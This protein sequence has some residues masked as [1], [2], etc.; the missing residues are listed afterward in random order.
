MVLLILDNYLADMND[1]V[2]DY[3]KTV[4]ATAAK[5]AAYVT[6]SRAGSAKVVQQAPFTQIADELQLQHYIEQGGLGEGNYS[7]WLD[8]YLDHSQHMHHPHYL[9]HQVAV[10]HLAEGVAD[11]ISGTINN[12]MA[13]YEMGPSAAVIERVVINWM[14]SKIGWHDGVDLANTPPLAGGIL[15]H[16]GSMANLTAMLAAR[17]AVAPEAWQNGNPPNLCVIGSEVAH[18]S[19]ARAI[20]IMGLGS[21]AM[22]PVATDDNEVLLPDDLERAY[23]LAQDKG[24]VVMAVIANACATSTGLY[25]PIAE[26]GDFC[27]SHGLWF[28]IDGAHG[29]SALISDDTKHYMAGSDLANSMI[30]DTHKML[31]TSTLAAA[32]LFKDRNHMASAFDQKGSYLFHE[33]EQPGIDTMAYTIEC[34]KAGLGT[35]LF[36][37]LAA[38]GEQSL[39]HFVASRYSLAGHY[40]TE[41]SALDDFEVPY[42]PEAN[43]LCFRY[44]P[45][46]SNHLQLAL[47]NRIVTRGNFYITSTEVNDVR[48]LRL[49]LINPYTDESHLPALIQEVR[50]AYIS[51][52]T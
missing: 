51:L 27:R 2:E 13:I 17:S 10:P 12:P 47:R 8:A 50:A 46:D 33:K 5:L 31:R 45:A 32:V 15:T 41:M 34:T 21:D 24:Q 3:K 30:W 40:A 14:L 25:D 38:E 37:S 26:M 16:G 29:A 35:K 7:A 48:Y 28:H 11:L 6:S 36:W 23:R 1:N 20:S 52:S 42:H 22:I 49:V 19:I 43:I 18:Y 4:D 39:A 44:R 9:G